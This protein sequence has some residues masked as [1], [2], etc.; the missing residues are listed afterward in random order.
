M[1]FPRKSLNLL[2]NEKFI[3]SVLATLK[4][5][6]NLCRKFQVIYRQKLQV[7]TPLW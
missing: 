5:I 4:D 7:D 1:E 2:V 3:F 6:E